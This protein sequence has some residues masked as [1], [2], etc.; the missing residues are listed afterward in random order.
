M[1]TPRYFNG[2]ISRFSAGG[3]Y[4]PSD[5]Q[6]AILLLQRSG[7]S[8]QG[9]RQFLAGET[10][11]N[12]VDRHKLAGIV[13]ELLDLTQAPPGGPAAALLVPAVMAA[14]DAA[15]RAHKLQD[16]GLSAAGAHRFVGGLPID[17]ADDREILPQLVIAALRGALPVHGGGYNAMTLDDTS[18]KEK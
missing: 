5:R 11:A 2:F 3:R 16:Y 10:V 4:S 12:D 1:T 17:G 14:R 9:I 8:N 6:A 15:R 18:G 13:G 7:L